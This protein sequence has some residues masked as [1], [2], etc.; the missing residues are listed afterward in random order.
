MLELLS[1][2][3]LINLILQM[4]DKIEELQCTIGLNS[5]NSSKLLSRDE[6]YKK[7]PAKSLYKKSEKKV[8]DN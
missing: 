4:S 2:E 1:K 3:E 5:V 7:P 8:E 6:V